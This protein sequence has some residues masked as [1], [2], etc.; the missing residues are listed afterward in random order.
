MTPHQAVIERLAKHPTAVWVLDK[1][2]QASTPASITFTAGSLVKAAKELPAVQHY[3]TATEA[4]VQI[5]TAGIYSVATVIGSIGVVLSIY[6]AGQWR[7]FRAETDRIKGE[8]DHEYRMAQL[9]TGEMDRIAPEASSRFAPDPRC[10]KPDDDTV[11]V[12]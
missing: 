7:K 6:T 4:I 3:V 1:M 5:V 12:K 11:D 2:A 8:R 9:R 10:A